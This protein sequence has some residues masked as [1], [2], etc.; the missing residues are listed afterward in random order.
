MHARAASLSCATLAD[1]R[2]TKPHRC[3]RSRGR[4][5][6]GSGGP[7]GRGCIGSSLMDPERWQRVTAVFEAA[8]L[9]EPPARAAYLTEACA[10]DPS[11]LADVDALL[12]GDERARRDETWTA[13]E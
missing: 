1:S 5:W 7:R 12:R 11:L 8:L 13:K 2:W 4:R 6:I 3:S 9:R 10:D